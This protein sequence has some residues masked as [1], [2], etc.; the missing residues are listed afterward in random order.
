MVNNVKLHAND[1]QVQKNV[2]RMVILMKKNKN[3]NAMKDTAEMVTIA[4]LIVNE[5]LQMN[6]HVKM[7][8]NQMKMDNVKLH[9]ND[10]QMN[11]KKMLH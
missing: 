6:A 4:K 1:E 3:V 9:V 11:V 10:D 8:V 7:I 2:V 5:D